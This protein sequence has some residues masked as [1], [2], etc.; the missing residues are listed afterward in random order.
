LPGSLFEAAH[1]EK[2]G[3]DSIGF[4]ILYSIEETLEMLAVMMA[5]WGFMGYAIQDGG[6]L[7]GRVKVMA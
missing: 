3:M 6:Y 1:T 5:I 4:G 2:H 7:G